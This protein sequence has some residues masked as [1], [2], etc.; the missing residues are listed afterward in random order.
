MSMT[1]GES[2]YAIAFVA[3]LLVSMVSQKLIAAA[4][5]AINEDSW[6]QRI[7]LK[8]KWYHKPMQKSSYL[9]YRMLQTDQWFKV[10]YFIS[11]SCS[12]MLLFLSHCFADDSPSGVP[13]DISSIAARAALLRNS[14]LLQSFSKDIDNPDAV[15]ELYPLRI[16]RFAHIDQGVA[17]WRV[18]S[19][20][21]HYDLDPPARPRPQYHRYKMSSLPFYANP[22]TSVFV[23]NL[24]LASLTAAWKGFH[25]ELAAEVKGSASNLVPIVLGTKVEGHH[26]FLQEVRLKLLPSVFVIIVTTWLWENLAFFYKMRLPWAGL[27]QPSS[28]RTT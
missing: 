19:L 20:L 2:Y 28:S 17:S 14:R 8:D 16:G 18:D 9:E 15:R 27:F 24:F 5:V 11:V 25:S 23:L 12:I 3:R 4:S 26:S 21:N 1:V 6:K 7:V 10:L 22:W 13:W